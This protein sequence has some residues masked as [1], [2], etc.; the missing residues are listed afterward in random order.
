MNVIREY[1]SGRALCM[2][3]CGKP[4]TVATKNQSDADRVKGQPV[5]FLRGHNNRRAEHYAIDADT[6]CWNWLLAATPGGYGVYRN[7]TAHR[8][9]YER[10]NG[11]IPAGMQ[12]DHL[13]R[14]KLCVNPKHLEAVTPAENSR[15]RTS[16][17]LGWATVE[18]IRSSPE[19][20]VE[21]ARRLGV[22]VKTV[23][24]VRAE[25]TWT[26]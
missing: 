8:R 19:S 23:L 2:C 14:N 9:A 15:R 25:R 16:N 3:G 18:I 5:R 12:I 10:A 13:C 11:P 24:A 26:R 7:N 17:V 1:R 22:H 20:G 6:G 4:T 21:L